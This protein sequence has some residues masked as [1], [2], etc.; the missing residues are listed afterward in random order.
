M[1]DPA[2]QK[3]YAPLEKRPWTRKRWGNM[4]VLTNSHFM[5]F[6]PVRHIRS[7]IYRWK[8][9]TQPRRIATLFVERELQREQE[10]VII[11]LNYGL[12]LS[13]C[14][15]LCGFHEVSHS[16]C[17]LISAVLQ[18]M[19]PRGIVGW[20]CQPRLRPRHG[21]IGPHTSTTGKRS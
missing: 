21:T 7:S 4:G 17:K 11:T 9:P 19:L 8:R 10:C 18:K 5:C 2:I 12:L 20:R 3:T 1:E 16:V 6:V 13:V 15:C 14:I